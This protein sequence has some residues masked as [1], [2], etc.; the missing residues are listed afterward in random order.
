MASSM[1]WLGTQEHSEWVPCV[2]VGAVTSRTGWIA[3]GSFL[4]GGAYQQKSTTGHKEYQYGW[5]RKDRDALRFITDLS[6]DVHG[7]G[8]IHWSPPESM[9]R[10]VLPVYHSIPRMAANEGSDSPSLIPGYRPA[11]LSTPNNLNPGLPAKSAGYKILNEPYVNPGQSIY[12]A[13]PPGY[14]L[15]FG[16]KGTARGSACFRV[17][18]LDR[19]GQVVEYSDLSLLDYD[20]NALTNLAVRGAQYG[21]V[22]IFLT[23]STRDEASVT[24]SGLL[25]QILPDGEPAPV[26]Q[27]YSGDGHSGCRFS[28]W[29]GMSLP[30]RIAD[31]MGLGLTAQFTEVGAWER[32]PNETENDMSSLFSMI[33]RDP[34]L[35]LYGPISRDTDQAP[36]S[37]AVRWP[38]GVQGRYTALAKNSTW[39]HLVDSWQITYGDVRTY[40][41]PRITRN[42]KSVIIN[43]PEIVV[44]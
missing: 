40:L 33:A 12:I 3:T 10:N 2:D 36:L 21:G 22:R 38:D 15:H 34:E 26:G 17:L 29:P 6:N 18:K 11:L 32:E 1:I 41:Q 37:F 23:R 8:L 20:T 27:F 9:D 16:A 14:T 43:A 25:A 4:N 42:E 39:P 30:G 44:S 13:I 7:T 31:K 28:S 35:I 24:L 19:T 5:Q